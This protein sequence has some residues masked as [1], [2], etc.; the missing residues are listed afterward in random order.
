MNQ[1]TFGDTTNLNYPSHNVYPCW[2]PHA[3]K[4]TY[5]NMTAGLM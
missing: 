5:L 2:T 4:L 1:G 3:Q